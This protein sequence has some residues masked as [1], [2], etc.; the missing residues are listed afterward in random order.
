MLSFL[1]APIRGVV[2]LFLAIINLAFH[3]TSIFLLSLFLL[4]PQ[5]WWQNMLRGMLAKLA[6]NWVLI[7]KH[8]LFRLLPEIEF[9][10]ELQADLQYRHCYVVT[11]N[12]QSWVDI[13]ILFNFF[14]LRI[15]F[16]KF[17]LK[18][19]LIY[20]PFLGMACWGLDMPFMKRYSKEYL[21]KHPEKRGKDLETTRKACEKF[22]DTPVA[23]VNF[24]EGTRFTPQ[25]HAKQQSPYQYLL[26]PKSGGLAFVLSAL[27]PQMRALL[28]VTIAYPDGAPTFLEMA[29][30][31][32][33]RVKIH[34][35]ERE[36]PQDLF[37]GDYENDPL[38]RERFQ[39]WVSDVWQEKDDRL[40]RMLTSP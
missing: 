14:S 15:P 16:L 12:H 7:N 21:D 37:N 18:H 3:G 35:I 33:R 39:T 31:K 27:G 1:P 2:F 25:K 22:K 23:V 6:E 9:E 20:V 13:V 28:D 30:G 19:E 10:V 32:I 29:C 38:F 4:I 8:V 5:K 17:F 26:R 40:T 36:I 11:A 24:L 34:V